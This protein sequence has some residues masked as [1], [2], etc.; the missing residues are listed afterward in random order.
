MKVVGFNG[1]ARKDGNTAI[2]INDVFR[3]LKSHGIETELF[4]MAGKKIT[5]CSACYRCAETKDGVCAIK[6]DPVNEWIEIMKSADAIILGSPVYFAD[7]TASM[8]GFIE[9][10]GM[11]SRSGGGLFKGKIGASVV[12]VRRVGAIHAFDSMNHFFLITEMIIC[13]REL[14]EYRNRKKH[15]RS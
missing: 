5:G 11:V 9:R 8:K 14:L 3:E 10:A 4:Q 15:R 13:G 12:A 2:L 6:D 1:S 7:L